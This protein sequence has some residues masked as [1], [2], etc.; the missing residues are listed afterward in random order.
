MYQAGSTYNDDESRR[1]YAYSI[2]DS[3]CLEIVR[4]RPKIDLPSSE[5][6]K[7]GIGQ[8]IIV[9]SWYQGETAGIK[10]VI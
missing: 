10:Q 4:R 1:Y 8:L 7:A 3:I 6:V 5:L 9:E 2:F